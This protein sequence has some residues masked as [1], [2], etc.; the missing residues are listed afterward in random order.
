MQTSDGIPRSTKKTDSRIHRTSRA[1]WATI[2][3]AAATLRAGQRVYI[4]EG[5]YAITEQIRPNTLRQ[6]ATISLSSQLSIVSAKSPP[7]MKTRQGFPVIL[8]RFSTRYELSDC[9]RARKSLLGQKTW[10][11]DKAHCTNHAVRR[12]IS[13]KFFQYPALDVPY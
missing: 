12:N 2:H 6:S 3:H 11:N 8:W 10:E 1:P 9:A 13:T 4:R 7:Y 5:I